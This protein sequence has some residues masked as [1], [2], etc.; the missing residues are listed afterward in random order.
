VPLNHVL[1]TGDRVEILTAKE[2]RPS[3]DWLNPQLGYLHTSRAKAK[4]FHWFKKQDFDLHC[5]QGQS[6]LDRELKGMH[7]KS[8]VLLPIL[9]DF[10]CHDVEDLYAALGRGDVK[11]AAIIARITPQAPPAPRSLHRPPIQKQNDLA[12]QLVIEGVGHLLTHF[13]KC[14]HPAPGDDVVGYMTIGRGVSIHRTDCLNITQATEDQRRRFLNASWGNEFLSQPLRN[15][16]KIQIEAYDSPVLLKDLTTLIAEAQIRLVALQTRI[17]GSKPINH[18]QLTLE[19]SQLE[20]FIQ[21]QK[22]IVKLPGLI[23]MKQMPY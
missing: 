3:R 2:E 17:V 8:D 6:I 13:A 20:H 10:N 21:L 15:I 7:L 19:V 5:Q 22:D 23:L 12:K 11:L 4:V 18:L 1:K 9:N 14:C 16:I